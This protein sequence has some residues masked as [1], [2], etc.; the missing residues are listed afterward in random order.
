MKNRQDVDVVQFLLDLKPEYEVAPVQILCSF[1]LP[2]LHEVFSRLS[3]SDS[4]L[5]EF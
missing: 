1:E 5:A 3:G 4:Q 2:S